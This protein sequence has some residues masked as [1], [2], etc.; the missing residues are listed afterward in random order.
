MASI[1]KNKTKSSDKSRRENKKE[2]VLGDHKK[3]YDLLLPALNEKQRRVLVAS[4]VLTQG[5]TISNA[6]RYSGISRKTIY[7][8]L[9]EIERGEIDSARIREVGGG[10]K[11][12]VDQDGL[13]RVELEKLLEPTMRG[14]P[15]SPL[16]WTTKSLRNLSDAMKSK[17][18]D[19]GKNIVASLLHDLGFSLQ[20]NR[21][22]NE[23]KKD[24]PDRDKQFQYINK[25]SAKKIRQNEPVI[26][27][28]TKKKELIGN[29]KNAGREWMPKGEPEE[30]SSH[31]FIDPDVPKAVPYGIYDIDKNLGYVNVGT[32]HDTSEFAVESIRR[33]WNELGKKIYKDSKSLTIFADSGGSNGYRV[34]LWKVTL[35]K[36]ANEIKKEIIVCHFPSGTSKWNKIE[37]RLFSYITKSWRGR[38]LVSY[39]V[40]VSLIGSTKTK[41]GLKV[42]AKLDKRK[43]MVGIKV[44]DEELNS[45]NLKQH[46]FHPEWNYSIL[47]T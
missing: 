3:R 41:K 17:G 32:D 28:D 43:Y 21:K 44:S 5:L 6:S 1:K 35:Q 22:V 36:F 20:S 25:L 39:K 15:T 19:I 33:W 23:G 8:S 10:R 14:E 46:R 37:H 42:K 24:H 13:I 2:L 45:V 34:K 40:V 9:S 26:S 30:V 27:V 16:K 4:D 38:P 18:F 29:Y 47:P 12:K 31:D 11:K 7:K